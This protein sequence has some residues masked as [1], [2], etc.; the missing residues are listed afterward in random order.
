MVEQILLMRCFLV[1]LTLP[2]LSF[3]VSA[4]ELLHSKTQTS[5][6]VLLEEDREGSTDAAASRPKKSIIQL[7]VSRLVD[8]DKPQN[9]GPSLSQTSIHSYYGK[10]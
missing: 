6:A 4:D 2:P 10:T 8:D 3:L 9:I 5:N 7:L 1:V